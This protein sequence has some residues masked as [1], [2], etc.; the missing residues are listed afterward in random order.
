LL[1]PGPK[2]PGNW[3]RDGEHQFFE[4]EDLFI[5]ID[6]G[7]EIY[8]EYGFNR[9]VIQDYKNDD[10][11]RLSLEIFEMRSS[12]SAYGMWTFKKGPRGEKIGL[13]DEGQLDDYYLNFCKGRYLV[14]V[15]GL[16]PEEPTRDGVI[17]IGHE[18]D[19]RIPETGVV[20]PG[21]IGLL[22][23]DGLLQSSIRY[24]RGPLGI[25]NSL[26]LLVKAA[27]GIEEGV[28]A[29]YESGRT[30]CVFRYP[31]EAAAQKQLTGA[32]AGLFAER[33]DAYSGI[34]GPV[35]VAQDD[36]GGACFAQLEDVYIVFG[37]GRI[38]PDQAEADLKPVI[39]NIR[40]EKKETR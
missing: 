6:G 26:P 30:I 24:F 19:T 14:T 10:G 2:G 22:P 21:L 32:K 15:T 35:L 20:R 12:E 4:G 8:L 34:A 25:L 29:D 37:T 40:K 33:L 38:D 36:R 16:I 11:R 17:A 3:T 7:A 9:V 31:D 13:G 1:L 27:A 23:R 28:R 5:Y 18:V 39:M